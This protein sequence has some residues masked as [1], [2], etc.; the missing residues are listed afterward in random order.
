MP[1]DDWTEEKVA[2]LRAGW[3][4]GESCTKIGQSIGV[5]GNAVAKKAKRLKLP[6]RQSPI[7]AGPVKP[8]I[9]T[10][11]ERQAAARAAIGLT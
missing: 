8:R 10:P 3:A 6:G 2:K 9:P 7:K 4:K 11:A 1:L 5:T